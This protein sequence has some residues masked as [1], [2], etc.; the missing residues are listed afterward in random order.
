M[1]PIPSTF[2]STFEKP[3]IITNKNLVKINPNFNVDILKI[4][5]N[6]IIG[7]SL[8]DFIIL[9]QLSRGSNGTIYKVRSRLN[10]KEYVLKKVNLKNLNIA[11]QKEV[12]KEAK[13][14]K[15]VKHPH[16]IRYYQSFRD[17]G[18]L[19]IIMEYAEGGDLQK[20]FLLIL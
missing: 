5:E 2:K 11:Q 14:L 8:Q 10:N 19:Y 6:D 12:F 13:I 1:F 20:V 4:N 7:N 18:S 15:K 3:M 16:I 17:D 9:S